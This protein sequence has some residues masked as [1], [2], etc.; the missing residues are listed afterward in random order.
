MNYFIEYTQTI[1]IIKLYI[2]INIYMYDYMDIHIY[3]YRYVHI[4]LW[5]CHLVSQTEA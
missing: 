3:I 5:S 1:L 2:Y 4:Y